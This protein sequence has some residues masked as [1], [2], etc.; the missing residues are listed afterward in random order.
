VKDEVLSG[1]LNQR[2]ITILLADDHPLVLRALKAEFV[3]AADFEVVGEASDGLEAVKLV[4]DL[5]PDVVIMDIGLPKL[6]GIEAIQQIKTNDQNTMVLVLTVYDDTEHILKVLES[7]ADGYLTKNVMVENIIRSTRL[8]ANGE[9][10]LSPQIFKQ[11]LRYSLRHSV[12]TLTLNTTIRLTI[13]EQDILKM[14]AKGSS[15]KQ[16]ASELGV[17]IGTI[18]SHLVDI[19]SKLNANSRTEAVI[20]GVQRG[21]L[22]IDDL[23]Y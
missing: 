8:I 21:L 3:K 7:G 19:F 20:N 23:G 13:H 15:N 1:E 14:L 18:K 5:K 2:K 16:I 11:V 10:V 4:V 6:N 9:I 22:K 12:K 17:Q